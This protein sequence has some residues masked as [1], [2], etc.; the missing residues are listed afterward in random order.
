MLPPSDPLSVTLASPPTST[1]APLV[2]ATSKLPAAAVPVQVSPTPQVT[3][4]AVDTATVDAVAPLMIVPYCR[5]LVLVSV[6]WRRILAV[7][8]PVAVAARAPGALLARAALAQT[9][10]A[11]FLSHL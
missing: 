5:S 10:R 3:P 8:V 6:N 1:T 11:R 2:P 7:A 4:P 9:S